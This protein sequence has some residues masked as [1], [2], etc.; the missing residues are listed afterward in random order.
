MGAGADA[1][2]SVIAHAWQVFDLPPPA[3]TGVCVRC[4]MSA[5]AEANF[6]LCAARDL[7]DRYVREWYNGAYDSSLTHDH[8]AWFLPRVME[9]LAA[10]QDIALAG[11]EVVFSRLPFAGFPAQWSK[12]EVEAVNRFA[13]AFFEAKLYENAPAGMSDIDSWLC[14]VGQGGIDIMPL[15]GLMDT[16]SDSDLAD[17]L[18]RN[19]FYDGR[20]AL[21]SNAF[22]TVE[23]AKTLVWN[24][25]R[26]PELAS[27]MEWA[28]MA[29]NENALNVHDL[30]CIAKDI[31][32][33]N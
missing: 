7:P 10:G 19:W 23:P 2:K 18:Y 25:Y 28:A 8:V 21:P 20:G 29:G 3:T 32:P 6:L 12:E 22:W 13:L 16:F 5:D 24:W 31:P 27:R 11:L 1:L 33:T 26:S 17:L 30:I 15:L 14:M 9:M 4:C